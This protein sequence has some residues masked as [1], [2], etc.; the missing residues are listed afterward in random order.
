MIKRVFLFAVIVLVAGLVLSGLRFYYYC[1]TPFRPGHPA[2]VE[3][4]IP[5]GATF[6]Q[7]AAILA[8]QGVIHHPLLFVLLAKIK[9][10]E[11]SVKAGPYSINVPVSPLDVLGKLV[12]G[13]VALLSVTFPEGS[14][15]FDIAR[16][17]GRAGLTPEPEVL[18]RVSDRAFA[19]SLGFDESTLEGCLFPDTYKFARSMQLDTMLRHMA[20]RFRD[21][22]DKELA[23][24]AGPRS[25]SPRQLLILASLVEKEAA[26]PAERPIIAAVFFNR[27]RLG[28]RLDCDPTVAYGVLLEDPTFRGR[29]RTKHLRAVNSYNTYIIHGLPAGPICNP[30][31][32]SI[33]AVLH[34]AQ[35]D[36]L[37]FVARNNGTHQ[38]SRTLE[39]HNQAV[40]LYQR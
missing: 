12:R 26:D 10:A 37:Y 7:T 17:F 27:L 38:F 29:L 15:M 9:K 21:V 23:K 8:R 6:R 24:D 39:E 3:V 36:Y 20:V 18:S 28:M 34:P 40:R 22:F 11:H 1:I 33:R 14:N 4:T 19:R 2:T 13:E 5:E 31:L 35:V 25:L 32:A 16:I 30:G